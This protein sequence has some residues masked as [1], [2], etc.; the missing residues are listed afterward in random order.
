MA[1]QT[2]VKIVCTECG[3]E[4]EVTITIGINA[5]QDPE[6]FIDLISGKLFLFECAG[7]GKK[8]HLNH[9]VIYQDVVHRAL[10]HYVVSEESMKKS[11]DAIARLT[12]PE[13]E[14]PLPADYTIRVVKNQNTLREKALMFS[15]GLDDRIMEIMKG[16]SVINAKK[17]HPDLQV[18][19]ALFLTKDGKWMLQLLGNK[20]LT[21]EISMMKYD[22]LRTRLGEAMDDTEIKRY[23]VDAD[24]ALRALK[25]P[26]GNT[27]FPKG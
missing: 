27:E 15:Y 10:I 13:G 19:E 12:D 3:H 1:Q 25:N 16:L 18:V 8:G 2:T 21:A 4:N 26:L 7:C 22:E 23:T 24:W 5:Q 9:D 11:Y 20:Q 6:K 17:D 14:N